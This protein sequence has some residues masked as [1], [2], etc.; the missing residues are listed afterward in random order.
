MAEPFESLYRRTLDSLQEILKQETEDLLQKMAG[1]SSAAVAETKEV[2]VK[3]AMLGKDVALR[4]ISPE[5]AEL[6]VKN[7]VE[8]LRLIEARIEVEAKKETYKK[9]IKI[10]N[11][12]K[13]I[14][15]SALQLGLEAA[16]GRVD[17]LLAQLAEKLLATA[18]P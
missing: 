9:A 16:S 1:V 15:L 17:Q 18:K 2:L 8:S 10:L 14:F 3:M 6:A 7:Y 12:I 5:T 11:K 4:K 13:T